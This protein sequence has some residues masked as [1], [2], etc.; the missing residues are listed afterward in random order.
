MPATIDKILGKPL[1]HTH[2]VSDIIGLTIPNGAALDTTS[3]VTVINNTTAGNDSTIL[4]DATSSP[5]TIT[6]PAA[7]TKTNYFYR[8][9]KID[10][11][12]NA[13][14]IALNGLDTLDGETTWIIAYKDTCM[15]IVSNGTN[16]YII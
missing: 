16:W 15:D 13:I 14:T 2:Q 3:V 4:V 10:A 1:M 12:A 9:K 8:I 11:S 6:L 7:S 5:I